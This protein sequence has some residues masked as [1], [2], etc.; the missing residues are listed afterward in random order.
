MMI[1]IT[2]SCR[3]ICTHCSESCTPD[4][5]H[6]SF[7]TFKQSIVKVKELGARVLLITG[8]EPTDHPQ[9]ISF[10]ETVIAERKG[11]PI[12]VTSNGMFLEDKEY[13]K[14]LLSLDC[15][16]QITAD[17]RY[18][19]IKVPV[20]DHPKLVYETRLRHVASIGR[21][22][23]NGIEHG[24]RKGTKCF[25]IRALTKQTGSITKAIEIL[26]TK[27]VGFCVPS[28]D[29]DGS[30]KPGEFRICKTLGTIWDSNDALTKSFKA[31]TLY[32]CNS[33]DDVK[34]LGPEMAIAF[35]SLK[36]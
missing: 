6:M 23:E 14:K 15:M 2:N 32:E 20:I 31:M 34:Y 3:M 27:G 36:D 10:M 9:F 5:E 22:R 30:V 8:G 12:I 26:E 19:P 11:M 1:K 21:A 7:D 29:I 25:N 24:V 33:C 16:Y 4:G 13:T 28:I 17:E 35:L 18:Y